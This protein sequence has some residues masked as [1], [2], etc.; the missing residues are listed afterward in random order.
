MS[1]SVLGELTAAR[2]AGRDINRLKSLVPGPVRAGWQA[3]TCVIVVAGSLLFSQLVVAAVVFQD[4]FNLGGLDGSKWRQLAFHGQTVSPTSSTLIFNSQNYADTCS[5]FAFSGS[6]GIVVEARMRGPGSDRDTSMQLVEALSGD[7]IT[8]GDTSYFIGGL[9]INASGQFSV[10]QGGTGPVTSTAQFKEYRFTASGSQVTIARGDTLA[11]LNEVWTATLA[12]SIS[13]KIFYLRIGSGGPTYAPGEFDWLRVNATPATNGNACPTAGVVSPTISSISPSTASLDLP[14]VFEL[15][16][17][18]LPVGLGF[19]LVDCSPGDAEVFDQETNASLR[20]FRCT[21]RGYAGLR[22]GRIS[23]SPSGALLQ[24]FQVNVVTGAAATDVAALS[25]DGPIAA[26]TAGQAFPVRI[27]AMDAGGSPV[28]A[29]NGAVSIGEIAGKSVSPSTVRLTAGEWTGSVVVRATGEARLVTQ[30]VRPDGMLVTGQSNGFAVASSTMRSTFSVTGTT[31]PSVESVQLFQEGQIS[32]YASTTADSRG[33]FV[34]SNVPSGRYS[35]RAYKMG[36]RQVTGL[37][38]FELAKDYSAAVIELTDSGKYAL[39]IPGMMGSTLRWDYQNGENVELIW[40]PLILGLLPV[41]GQFVGSQPIIAPLLPKERVCEHDLSDTSDPLSPLTLYRA[42][43]R[44]AEIIDWPTLAAE[45][46]SRSFTVYAAPWDWRCSAKD[47]AKLYLSEAIRRI[48]LQDPGAEIH[49]VA[50]SMGGLVARE[51]IQS[52]DYGSEARPRVQSL[53]M[54]GTPNLGSTKAYYLMEGA[55]FRL[56]DKVGAPIYENSVES[57]Y[58]TANDRGLTFVSRKDVRV[59]IQKNVLGGRDLMPTYAF[60]QPGQFPGSAVPICSASPGQ[61]PHGTSAA[62]SFLSNLNAPA[63]ANRYVPFTQTP[64][65]NQVRAKLFLSNGEHTDDVITYCSKNKP[66]GVYPDGVPSGSTSRASGDGTVKAQAPV[67]LDALMEV[68]DFGDHTDMV[69]ATAAQV[70]QLLASVS[71]SA[72][73]GIA[74]APAATT[75]ASTAATSGIRVATAGDVD[76]QAQLPNGATVGTSE[77]GTVTEIPGVADVI[78]YPHARIVNLFD[79]APGRYSV[80]LRTVPELART[81]RT[82]AFEYG[83]ATTGASTRVEVRYLVG[84]NPR[85]VSWDFIA[86]PV[87]SISIAHQVAPPGAVVASRQPDGTRLTWTAAADPLVTG[88]RIYRKPAAEA[89]YDLLGSTTSTTYDTGVPWA[90][91]EEDM[92]D[93]VVVSVNAAGDESLLPAGDIASNRGYIVADFTVPAAAAELAKGTT[94]PV[95]LHFTDA[96]RSTA[97]I[98]DWRWDLDGDG[99]VDS[100]AQ[101]PAFTYAAY[102]KYT[103]GLD[104]AGIEGEDGRIKT[105]AVTVAP[106]APLQLATS[107]SLDVNGDGVVDARDGTLILRRMLGFTGSGLTEGLV[108]TACRSAGT[109]D[110]IAAFVDDQVTA[111]RFNVD[112]APGNG[113]AASNGLLIYR[114]LTGLTG[115]AVTA[116]VVRPGAV[117]STWDGTSQ[118]RDYLNTQCGARL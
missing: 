19:S 66:E 16:G 74:R 14:T 29:F 75:R 95:T 111:G 61:S 98:T 87:A 64:T 11:A 57:L 60:L 78:N 76:V 100:T 79:P 63:N 54:I 1:Q 90:S 107:C 102:G 7:T 83:V 43:Y 89:T 113:G 40:T 101:N 52:P 3:L 25:F 26:Q 41:V 51:Y 56:A 13:G 35:L 59:F 21:P 62:N 49:L 58:K 18:Q 117:R 20:K 97:A 116:N 53:V 6:G 32:P 115:D 28:T 105:F 12:S 27:R 71:P 70:A 104:V 17:S 47:A 38:I 55:D 34:F 94:L 9:Y 31:L 23:T 92:S 109:A 65:G 80:S 88:Y 4:D 67:F 82:A 110:I 45:L 91:S 39:L 69:G 30:Y 112:G 103:I 96:S 106:C 99:Q 84:A 118:I 77:A 36:F 72:S 10:P 48:R 86:A 68:G 8:A 46:K 85:T 22:Y 5:K 73:V 15:R 108:T 114:A 24:N 33:R 37:A 44:T 2:V 50:H 93:F 42:R 81:V